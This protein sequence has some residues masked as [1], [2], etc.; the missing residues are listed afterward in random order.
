M[1][2]ATLPFLLEITNATPSYVA[3]G[4]KPDT[5]LVLSHTTS[6]ASLRIP[7][8]DESFVPRPL[9][10]RPK[11][12]QD[13]LVEPQHS[14]FVQVTRIADT[15]HLVRRPFPLS[16]WKWRRLNCL[17]RIVMDV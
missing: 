7:F 2:L 11:F 1:T 13:T 3:F 15:G 16:Q 14:N 10:I 4:A 8:D 5:L 9:P 12:V 6:C 17:G